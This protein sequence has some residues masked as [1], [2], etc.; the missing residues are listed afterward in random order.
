[1]LAN[2]PHNPAMAGLTHLY[3]S[4]GSAWAQP[5]CFGCAAKLPIIRA[6]SRLVVPAALR[7]RRPPGLGTASLPRPRSHT[8][9]RLAGAQFRC[10]GWAAK[11]PTT[12][13][14]LNP[15]ALA[16]PQSRR[17]FGPG[18]IS[19]T[20]HAPNPP[21]T[22]PGSNLADRP[23]PETRRPGTDPQAGAFTPNST[24]AVSTDPAVR[25]GAVWYFQ[26]RFVCAMTCPGG[27]APYAVRSSV[28]CASA[29]SV[30]S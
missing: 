2:A 7:R 8:T 17:P 3:P 23:R 25:P 24:S 26:Y 11:P 18:T 6:G 12:W 30:T 16:A 13:P 5:R 19:L 1:M 15:T 28:E 29:T 9:D 4:I 10:S 20:G 22:P 27:G 14:G 21:T